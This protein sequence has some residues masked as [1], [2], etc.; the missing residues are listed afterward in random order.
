M[1]VILAVQHLKILPSNKRT[2]STIHTGTFSPDSAK[3]SKFQIRI[4]D[5]GS[6]TLKQFI[7]LK[8]SRILQKKF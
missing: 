4:S 3:F 6:E 5:S 1:V 7:G 8:K 2:G